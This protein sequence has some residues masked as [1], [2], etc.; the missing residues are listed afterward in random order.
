MT[1]NL[2]TDRGWRLSLRD[3]FFAKELILLAAGW[4]DY[5]KAPDFFTKTLLRRVLSDT[6]VHSVR[7]TH[8][9]KMLKDLGFD[10][11]AMTSCVTMWG[12]T[13]DHLASIPKAKAD[14]VVT[15]F[16]RGKPSKADKAM[17]DILLERYKNVYVWPQGFNDY[18]YVIA[19]AGSRANV[20]SPTLEAYDEILDGDEPIDYV[21]VRLHAGIRALQ[22]KRRSFIISIDNRAAEISRDT[23]LGAIPRNDDPT[24]I[25]DRFES[26]F[27]SE[28]ALPSEAIDMWMEQFGQGTT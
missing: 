17:I 8:T 4:R 6:A 27:V 21:G 26:D 16:T 15:T 12:L 19:M 20:L 18:D 28:L 25:A 24:E 9:Y 5:Q 11:V 2:L 10:N 3:G 22:K 1:S 13:P 14:S 23:G 7:D